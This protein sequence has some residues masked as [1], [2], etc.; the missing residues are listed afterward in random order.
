[1]LISRRAYAPL[2]DMALTWYLELNVT[3]PLVCPHMF[4]DKK[5]C[6]TKKCNSW[7]NRQKL[8]TSALSKGMLLTQQLID[9]DAIR[10]NLTV[11]TPGFLRPESLIKA[12]ARIFSIYLTA[13]Y[14]QY[15]IQVHI[16]THTVMHPANY[17]KN[18]IFD[19]RSR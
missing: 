7:Y 8:K 17:M 11:P 4:T 2:A 9:T 1:M 3:L 14:N 13:V 10:M 5:Q 15:Y 18:V 6:Y 12:L 19:C 16:N